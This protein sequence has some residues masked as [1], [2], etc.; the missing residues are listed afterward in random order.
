MKAKARVIDRNMCSGYDALR[1]YEAH[2]SAC[3]AQQRR[4]GA[5][6]AGR[7]SAVLGHAAAQHGLPVWEMLAC[8]VAPVK[9]AGKTSRVI[10]SKEA[11]SMLGRWVCMDEHQQSLPWR[12]QVGGSSWESCAIHSSNDTGNACTVS[13]AL[14][15]INVCGFDNGMPCWRDQQLHLQGMTLRTQNL[16]G[17]PVPL[18]AR[19]LANGNF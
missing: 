14:E 9:P 13:M 17:T 7:E 16:T 5:C 19:E 15:L 10:R 1:D 8:N 4:E 2:C 18:T 3:L 11:P 6:E 12:R